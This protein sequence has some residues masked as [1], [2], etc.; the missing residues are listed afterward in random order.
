MLV[1]KKEQIE[2]FIAEDD[3]QLIRVITEIVREAFYDGVKDHSDKTLESMAKIGIERA[4]SR[5]FERA[6]D[7]A[8]FVAIMFE[9]SPGFDSVEQIDA[10]LNDEAV[11]VDMRLEQ[12]AGRIPDD[13]WAE[14]EMTYDSKT[15]FPDA[16]AAKE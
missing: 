7:I 13:V 9:I 8:A 14:A 11:P 2:K 12:M 16:P 15:W 4:K 3:T 1:I 10:L 5:K 6:E